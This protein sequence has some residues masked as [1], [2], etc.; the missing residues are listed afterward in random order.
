MNIE[1][2]QICLG[3]SVLPV[4]VKIMAQR[5]MLLQHGIKALFGK[6]DQIL[7]DNRLIDTILLHPSKRLS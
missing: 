5:C 6:A 3:L 7:V 4:H 1:G 2:S